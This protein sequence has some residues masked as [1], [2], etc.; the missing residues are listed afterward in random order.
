M[1]RILKQKYL[2]ICI[3]TRAN[4]NKKNPHYSSLTVAFLAYV[5]SR[6]FRKFQETMFFLPSKFV[7]F[8]VYSHGGIS[9]ELSISKKEKKGILWWKTFN[10]LLKKWYLVSTIRKKCRHEIVGC[11]NTFT[12]RFFLCALFFQKL[13]IFLRKC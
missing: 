11:V 2:R 8:L 4:S 5:V 6:K 13:W 3:E 9:P 7:S 10:T 12:P 1:K